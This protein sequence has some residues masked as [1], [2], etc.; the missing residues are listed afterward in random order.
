MLFHVIVLPGT[1]VHLLPCILSM[2]DQSDYSYCI[3]GNALPA[4]ERA[5]LK[6]VCDRYPRLHFA[7]L[8][9]RNL[10]PHGI[11]LD[12]IW[13]GW[14]QAGDFC[15][16]DPDI[17]ADGAFP[18]EELVD[19]NAVFSSCSRIELES[20]DAMKPGFRGGSALTAPD[21]LPL[22]TSYF[23]VYR[24]EPLNAIQTAYGVGFCQYWRSGQVP[25]RAQRE[26]RSA[27]LDE[28]LFDTGKLQG[29]LL[30]RSGQ[31]V[32]YQALDRLIHVGGLT[33]RFLQGID[34][35]QDFV[36]D[37]TLWQS[38]PTQGQPKGSHRTAAD[39]HRK[40]I[41]AQYVTAWLRHA[42]DGTPRPTREVT[43]PAGI[44]QTLSR[45]EKII[46][47]TALAHQQTLKLVAR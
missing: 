14:D 27:G 2:H 36:L 43:L 26:L 25:I 42:V 18:V 8:P 16:C 9:G 45:V 46:S 7:H 4:D 6:Q 31:G 12:L 3:V 19:G 32:H 35:S 10:V 47:E 40:R 37:D 24:P 39:R 38:A 20:A 30:A 13:Q 21:G 28:G 11:A 29:W 15:F 44:D 41:L 23:A 34:F 1:A 22:P 17:L 33:G 5:L